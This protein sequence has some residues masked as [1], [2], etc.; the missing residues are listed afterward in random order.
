MVKRIRKD[1]SMIPEIDT[2]V[3]P[4][5]VIPEPV[6]VPEKVVIPE[7]PKNALPLVD[8]RPQQ[9]SATKPVEENYSGHMMTLYNAYRRKAFSKDPDENLRIY[10]KKR[11]GYEGKERTVLVTI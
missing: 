5:E 7:P 1:Y 2:E 6:V 10:N 11:R 8:R 4:E 3:I 9:V